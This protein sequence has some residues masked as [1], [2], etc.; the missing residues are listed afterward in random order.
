ML[1]V[2][3]V[4]VVFV[5]LDVHGGQDFVLAKVVDETILRVDESLFQLLGVGSECSL[6]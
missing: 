2:V 6:G 3:I 1:E 4:S 5:G